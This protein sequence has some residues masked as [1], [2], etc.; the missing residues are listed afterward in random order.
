MEANEVLKQ[1]AVN[2]FPAFLKYLY[3]K[4]VDTEGMFYI[5]DCHYNLGQFLQDE[6]ITHKRVGVIMSRGSLKTTVVT[7]CFSTWLAVRNPNVRILIVSNS[8][9]NAEKKVSEI[10]AIFENNKRFRNLFGNLVGKRRWSSQCI[11]LQREAD[12]Q[13]GTFESAGMGT[14]LTGRHYDVI[15]ED[16]TSAP[17]LTDYKDETDLIPSPETIRKAI[18]WN[19]QSIPLCTHPSQT[20]RIL[21]GTRWTYYDIFD[22]LKKKGGWKFFDKPAIADIE[23]KP[24]LNGIPLYKRYSKK[25][26]ESIQKELSTYLFYA[27]YLNSPL[28]AESMAF[29]PDFIN[30]VDKCD[31][32]KGFGIIT[33]D[34]AGWETDSGDECGIVVAWHSKPNITILDSTLKRMPPTETVSTI[35]KYCKQ[36][37]IR[38]VLVE[39]AANQYM[40]VKHI[41]DEI[42]KSGE[43]I[44]I[45]AIDTGGKA[46]EFRVMS[47][48]PLFRNK[49]I[50]FIR[51]PGNTKLTNQILEYPY[52]KHDD[53][54]DSLAYQVIKYTGLNRVIE[55]PK[56]TQPSNAIKADDVLDWIETKRNGTRAQ[57]PQL[58]LGRY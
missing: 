15:I 23:G 54:V 39:K 28:P 43:S 20:I 57:M 48:E 5:D 37:N 38:R 19:V 36:Y 17:D 35:F 18:N 16:D 45:E 31:L 52:G 55:K 26:L 21:V 32:T 24:D 58:I 51:T 14:Q 40:Y 41:R 7:K 11:E 12:F 30:F 2:S 44:S 1:A 4:D 25:V 50:N 53:G 56:I 34:T 47:L 46:K 33:V 3:G 29:P 9:T 13:E 6:A 10:A 49:Q 8:A 27:L 22:Y 42:T